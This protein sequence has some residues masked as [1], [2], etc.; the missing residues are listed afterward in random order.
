MVEFGTGYEM[1][2]DRN[3]DHVH[4]HNHGFSKGSEKATGDVGVKIGDMGMSLGMGPVP[5][6][7]AVAAKLRPGAKKL[8]FVFMGMGKG[9]GQGQTPG[10]YGKKQ[11]QA[12]LELGKAN[13]VDFTTHST[14]GVYGLAGM[15][16]Q[17][18][19][20]KASKN[21]SLQEVKR[22][23]EFAADVG[24]GGPIVVHTGEF[25]RPIVDAAWNQKK[26]DEYA[27]KFSM[28]DDEEG[29]T[30][31]KVVDVRTGG[32]IQEARKNRKVS[33]PVWNTAEVGQEYTDFDGSQRKTK[34]D[35][36]IYV[37]YFGNRL[38]S[39]ERVPKYNSK[40]GRFEVHQMGWEELEDEAKEM[41]GRARDLWNDWKSGKISESDFKKSYWAKFKDAE[42]EKE[43][44]V[45]P[46]EAYIIS[47]LE[48]NASNS[49]GWAVYYGG[50]FD[51]NIETVK[52]LRKARKIYEKIEEATDE[53]E[54]WKL[55]IQG[56]GLLGGLIPEEAEFP[57][58]RIDKLISQVEH[59]LR[60]SRESAASQWAQ[61][62]ESLETIRNVES[63]ETYAIREACDAYAQAAMSSMRQTQKLREAGQLKKPLTVALENLFPEHYGSHPDEL[64]NLVKGSRKRFVDLLKQ[65]GVA[66][67]EAKKRA[68]D[69]ITATFDT[70]HLN[71]WRKY[72]RG[73]PNKSLKD[74]DEEFNQWSLDKV[75]EM[76][77]KGII[78]HV[79]IDDNYGYH[80]DHLAPGEGNTPIKGMIKILKE[81]G[82]DG[83]LIIEPGADYTTDVTGFHSVMK[84][85][86]HFGIPVYGKGS[87]LEAGKR[88]WNQ[89][90]Y[91]HFGQNQPPYFVFG[92][93]SPSEDWTLWSGVPLE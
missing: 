50:D 36:K 10:M 92:A 52:K 32:L 28:F 44:V 70:G 63:A 39:E 86:R 54:K 4:E 34:E 61:A 42:S 77:Q 14:V 51:E 62:E 13:K 43:V 33:K 82:Y 12:F 26:G 17:G 3:Y 90:G 48:T 29:R 45:R 58:E 27:G 8:E 55:Q 91:G 76:A 41:T 93:Y 31:Y 73:D 81:N 74:N 15:D 78:G 87:G 47:T 20:S 79:H 71:M 60:Y 89:I 65:Q 72:W 66:E 83:E 24:R 68:K 7:N 85:W 57:T 1:P 59:K 56:Q 5:N 49:R 11:R 2:M 88:G 35:E 23:I 19:F 64:I 67:E 69:H 37:D 80:D 9:S 38:N 18:N 22:A 21:Q 75:K 6:V 16:Q 84:T 30:S 25:S 46:E 53:E 40:E